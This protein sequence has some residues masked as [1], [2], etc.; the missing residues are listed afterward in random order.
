MPPTHF[1][2]GV[3]TEA[4]REHFLTLAKELIGTDSIESVGLL[5]DQHNDHRMLVTIGIAGVKLE[6][7]LRT[8]ANL[9]PAD[10][11]WPAL[12]PRDVLDGLTALKMSA[13]WTSKEPRR[14]LVQ[15]P[16]DACGLRP[17]TMCRFMWA[18]GHD[19]STRADVNLLERSVA[20]W[21]KEFLLPKCPW[22]Y[23]AAAAAPSSYGIQMQAQ[24]FALKESVYYDDETMWWA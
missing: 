23:K 21:G 17:V 9:A 18:K 8:L 13:G 2:E 10:F 14:S 6:E 1:N 5:R 7:G 15:T 22:A 20:Y 24:K 16:L 3:F 11:R 4:L 19:G 12:P